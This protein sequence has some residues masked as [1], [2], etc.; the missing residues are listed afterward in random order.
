MCSGKPPTHHPLKVM[1][2]HE[3]DTVMQ[4]RLE[5]AGIM[6]STGRFWQFG[7]TKEEALRPL[8]MSTTALVR[9]LAL[10]YIPSELISCNGAPKRT[11]TRTVTQGA[12]SDPG[13]GNSG[14]T[15]PVIT[16][17]DTIAP[18]IEKII[19]QEEKDQKIKEKKV[20]LTEHHY[21]PCHKSEDEQTSHD[22][23]TL[24]TLDSNDTS[25]SHH[26][27]QAQSKPSASSTPARASSVELSLDTS[28]I[29]SR[30]KSAKG[31][32]GQLGKRLSNLAENLKNERTKKTRSTSRIS[33]EDQDES[34]VE[35]ECLQRPHLMT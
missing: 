18:L 5:K 13:E 10:R 28:S 30:M 14:I 11:V 26:I 9:Q 21:S 32:L 6:L 4:D 16:I 35:S 33:E 20:P 3:Y 8:P 34:I 27:S 2:L 7:M 31:R 15:P 1:T 23:D 17:E 19:A 12:R 22:G 29:K 25:N 24:V